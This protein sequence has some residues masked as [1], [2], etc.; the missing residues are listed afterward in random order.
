MKEGLRRSR[1]RLTS[2]LSPVRGRAGYEAHF[3]SVNVHENHL[4]RS[5]TLSDEGGVGECGSQLSSTSS[6]SCYTVNRLGREDNE[7]FRGSVTIRVT[8]GRCLGQEKEQEE[9]R[10]KFEQE[11]EA[12][13]RIYN[14]SFHTG[15]VAGRP[16]NP[17]P[18]GGTGQERERRERRRREGRKEKRER[19]GE[20]GEGGR[21]EMEDSRYENVLFAGEEKGGGTGDDASE[22]VYDQ[23]K[24]LKN[25]VREVNE[26][27]QSEG[28]GRYKA[29][30]I[31]VRGEEEEEEEEEGIGEYYREEE[32]QRQ[33]RRIS[34]RER[35][36][37]E[38]VVPLYDHPR[39]LGP[40]PTPNLTSVSCGS[41]AWN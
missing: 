11:K 41:S 5:Y 32:E 9:R 21:R 25:S 8:T 12:V 17:I 38:T 16:Q 40:R 26:I 34:G 2:A 14:T 7:D 30:L 33:R 15:S 4:Y 37:E 1:D 13:M 28:E 19:T 39:P 3:R 31:H 23:V 10:S 6:S 27:V 36:E 22:T 20:G 29:V 24:L 18:K 35:R